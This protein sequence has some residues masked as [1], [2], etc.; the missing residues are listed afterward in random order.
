MLGVVLLL[1]LEKEDVDGDEGYA[2]KN[3][4]QKVMAKKVHLYAEDVL[5]GKL[6]RSGHLCRGHRGQPCSTTLYNQDKGK[7]RAHQ[8]HRLAYG[9]RKVGGLH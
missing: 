2:K 3:G 7:K 1:I 8:Y 4:M 6:Q 9:K 5:S